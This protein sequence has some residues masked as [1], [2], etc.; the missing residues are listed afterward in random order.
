MIG[1]LG[2]RPYTLHLHGTDIRG[3]RPGSLWGR[4]S[5]PFLKR[6][7]L[8]YYSTPDLR[9]WVE[10]FRPTPSSCPTRSRPTFRPAAELPAADRAPRPAGRRQV[11]PRS[12]ASRR[13]SRRSA[14]CAEPAPD[15]D[16][17][18]R[19]GRGSGRG[20]GRRGA[21]RG[22]RSAKLARTELPALFRG[23]RLA[24]GQMLVGAIGN[25]ELECSCLRRARGDPFRLR[26]RLPRPPPIVAAPVAE[27]AAAR[28]AGLLDDEA[29]AR[30]SRRGARLG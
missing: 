5:G 22:R 3:V 4:E 9:E 10:P 29:A 26:R 8:V 17:D 28:I 13:S 15:D 16:H 19:P 6:A 12:R 30:G 21:R 23:H 7:R 18:R 2:G 27:E 1:V 20:R 11:S 25:Y 14:C 24:L